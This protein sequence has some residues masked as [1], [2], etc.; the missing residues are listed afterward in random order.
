MLDCEEGWLQC[1]TFDL[2]ADVDG[3]ETP[4]STTNCG[5]CGTSCERPNAN[6]AC[7]VVKDQCLITS[8]HTGYAN[9]DGDPSNACEVY[10]ATDNAHCGS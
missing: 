2:D 7:D 9:C 6:V 1:D 10:L 4:E 3:C 5:T 8:C